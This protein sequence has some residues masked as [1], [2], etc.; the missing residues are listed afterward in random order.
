MK[1]TPEDAD[2]KGS[3]DP[4]EAAVRNHFNGI[5]FWV[6]GFM[7]FALLVS[8]VAIGIHS[9]NQKQHK[10]PTANESVSPKTQPQ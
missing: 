6:L 9:H 4:S 8:V 10:D 3:S 7:V 2:S 1:N 5:I